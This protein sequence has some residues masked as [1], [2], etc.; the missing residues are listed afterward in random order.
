[1]YPDK[2]NAPLACNARGLAPDKIANGLRCDLHLQSIPD[3]AGVELEQRYASLY[4]S[5]P[6]LEI[7]GD[8]RGVNTWVARRGEQIEELWL[9]RVERDEVRVLNEAIPVT[10]E[11]V[12]AFA[13]SVF[14]AHPGTHRIVFNAVYPQLDGLSLP[15]QRMQSTDDSVITLPATEEA[16][17][18]SLGKSTRKN[19][20]RYLQRLQ[21]AHP[22]FRYEIHERD[23]VS[24]HLLHQI[25]LLNHKRMAAKGKVSGLDAQQ[26]ARLLQL[27]RRTGFI[28]IASIDGQVCAGA[29]VFKIG[30]NFFSF[31]RAHDA[32]Y[33]ECRL[34]LIGGFHLVR[35]CIARGGKEL[36]LMWG[37]E[38]HKALLGAQLREME[39]VIVF[40]SRVD[41]LRSAD[42]IVKN[43]A[44]EF[45]RNSKRRLLEKARR[46]DDGV[47]RLLQRALKTVRRHSAD[48]ASGE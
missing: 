32:R 23:A 33:D 38:P 9:Y 34:G 13:E 31:V 3:F 48:S 1:M 36:H 25:V 39:R 42:L 20:K 8:P 29:I 11:A 21:E 27:A 44:A 6:Q 7:E 30:C 45:V 40:R 37:R 10:S 41:V 28:G 2:A 12:E 46:G 26:E 16:Y 47:A 35:A 19:I 5:L 22:S 24:A 43:H 18:E 14:A 4:A 17:L 15:R